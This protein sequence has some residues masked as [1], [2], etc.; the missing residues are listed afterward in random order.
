[1]TTHLDRLDADSARELLARVQ[2]VDALASVAA[3]VPALADAANAARAALEAAHA[4]RWDAWA[5]AA[6]AIVFNDSHATMDALL[7]DFA[8]SGGASRRLAGL[9]PYQ[10]LWVHRR[11]EQMG[12]RT[13]SIEPPDGSYSYLKDVEVVKPPGWAMPWGG[14]LPFKVIERPR[15]PPPSPPPYYVRKRRR[16]PPPSESEE[17]EEFSSEGLLSGLDEDWG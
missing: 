5:A 6:P 7:R 2:D 17:S 14:A 4:A 1:M 8:L 13:T 10:R 11:A 15:A 12:M 3:A 9:I 16:T